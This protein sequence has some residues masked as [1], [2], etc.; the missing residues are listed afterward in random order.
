MARYWDDAGLF[1]ARLAI[2]YVF[3]Y[4]AYLNAKAENREWLVTHTGLLFPSGS[5]KNL[6]KVAAC[7]GVAMMFAGGASMF[8]G[9][10]IWVG[11]TMLIAFTVL[12]YLQHRKEVELSTCLANALVAETE[13]LLAAATNAKAIRQLL[14]DLRVSAYS[15]QFSSGLKNWGLIGG[16]MVLGFVTGSGQF[17]LDALLAKIRPNWLIDL[18][19]WPM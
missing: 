5:S 9:L 10:A 7:V 14:L 6:I 8:L 17:S 18:I 15:G 3:L 1:L 19:V 4:A 12:G 2:A 16:L 11:A 13:P